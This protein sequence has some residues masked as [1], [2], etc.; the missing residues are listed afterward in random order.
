MAALLANLAAGASLSSHAAFM[1]INNVA[2]S[3]TKA[4]VSDMSFNEDPDEMS[5]TG[6]DC[7]RV[8]QSQRVVA[9]FKHFITYSTVL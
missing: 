1:D 5:A 4:M 7:I 2:T 6:T 9:C 3:K 8:T